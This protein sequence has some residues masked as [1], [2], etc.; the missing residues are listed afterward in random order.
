S[1]PADL[2]IGDGTGAAGS[3]V[4]L[5][6]SGDQIEDTS[7]VTIASDGRLS[8]STT[9]TETVG[10]IAGPGSITIG[11]GATLTTGFNDSST[12]F[13]GVLGG[14]VASLIKLGA[15]TWTLTGT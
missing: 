6:Q 15:G 1:V 4:V 10:S 9:F 14:A 13:S 12:T 3:A 2:D 8:L 7:S 5:I 11:A